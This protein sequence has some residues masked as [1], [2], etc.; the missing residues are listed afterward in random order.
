MK[1]DFDHIAASYD[2]DFT[3]SLIGSA[4]REVVYRFL[5]KYMTAFSGL[6][7]LELNC[8]TGAD[9]EWLANQNA[10]VTATD[11][12]PE[13]VSITQRRSGN[14]SASVLDI[15]ELKEA[16]PTKRFDVV[17]S[18]FGGLNCLNEKDLEIALEAI[19]SKLKI[20]GKAFLVIM[21]DTCRWE[22]RYFLSKGKF[23]EAFRRKNKQGVEANVDGVKVRTWY[24]SPAWISEHSS[25]K[26]MAIHPV[27]SYLPP[28]YLEPFVQ[29]HPRFF[30]RLE[31]MERRKEN[32]EKAA[33][34]SD[35][36]FIY[37]QR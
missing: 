23:S 27:G 32:S 33:A 30:Q 21:P 15:K 3:H 5:K 37:L 18:N 29:K 19:K 26:T 14:I 4:Q 16:F 1:Q 35:H 28:S 10:T 12:S 31:R 25:M 24:Y 34:R 9:A 2:A 11:I 36:F 22:T 6:E 17:F 13:M 20:G 7:V 8:G